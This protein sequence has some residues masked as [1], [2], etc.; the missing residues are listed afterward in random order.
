MIK[1]IDLGGDNGLDDYFEDSSILLHWNQVIN[2][3]RKEKTELDISLGD[4]R[5]YRCLTC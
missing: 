4:A 2:W 1:L 5:R 3:K